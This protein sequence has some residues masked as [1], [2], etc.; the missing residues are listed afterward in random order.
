[1]SHN[2]QHEPMEP[3]VFWA[4]MGIM[5]FTVIIFAVFTLSVMYWG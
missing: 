1:M 5:M 3:W 2:N 4:G